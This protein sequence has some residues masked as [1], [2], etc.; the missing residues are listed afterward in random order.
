M[1]NPLSM[2]YCDDGDNAPSR[3]N[4]NNTGI[5]NPKLIWFFSYEKIQ[6]RQCEIHI[7]HAF[8]TKW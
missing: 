4:A 1:I 5:G 6:D 3:L 2:H 7:K 8:W